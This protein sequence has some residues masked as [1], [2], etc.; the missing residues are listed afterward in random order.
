MKQ[1]PTPRRTAQKSQIQLAAEASAAQP[2]DPWIIWV[3]FRRCWAWA[4]P[5]GLVL[6]AIA[7]VVVLQMFVPTY[8]ATHII[9]ANEE[10]LLFKGVH[11]VNRNLA[12]TEK[13]L[14]LNPLVLDPVLANPDLRSAPSLSD[15]ETAESNLK[16]ALSFS[17][18]G[19]EA[20]LAVSYQDTTPEAAVEVCNA[21]VA[22]YMKFRAA[23][24]SKRVR[25]LETWLTPEIARWEQEVENDLKVVKDLRVQTNGYT[26]GNQA[27]QLENNSRYTRAAELRS[28]IGDL[29][30]AISIAEAGLAAQRQGG[31]SAFNEAPPVLVDPEIRVKRVEPTDFEITSQVKNDPAVAEVRHRIQ[32]YE[33]L[34]RAIEDQDRVGLKRKD[35]QRFKQLAA[36]AKLELEKVEAT[37]RVETKKKLI[38]L[39][40]DRYQKALAVAIAEDEA[41]RRGYEQRRIG[42]QAKEFAAEENKLKSLQGELE[43]LKPLYEEERARLEQYG[44]ATAELDFAEGELAVA[45]TILHKLRDRSAQIRTERRP[46]GA[47]RSLAEATLPRAAVEDLPYKQVFMVS[48]LAM[49]VPFLLGLLIE[50]RH[51][52]ITDSSMCDKSGLSVIGE[53]AQLPSGPRSTKGRRVF[54]ESIDTLRSSLFLSIDTKDTRSIAVVSSMSGEGKSSVSSQLAISIAKATG[55]TVL[56]VDADLRCPD[57][58]EIFGLDLGPGLSAVLSEAVELTDAIDKSLG[59]FVHVIPAGKL[60][61]SPHRL[62]TPQR[63]QAFIDLALKEYAYVVVDTAPVLSAG[64]SLAVASSV[65]ASLLCV[66]RDL[67]RVDSVTRTTR[68]LEA[69]GATIAGTVFSGVTAR[70]YAY[71]YGNYHYGVVPAGNLSGTSSSS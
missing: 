4:L 31:S 47:V 52:R 69:A 42:M 2:F 13:L 64:E 17:S 66:M 18:S 32:R 62:I 45:T 36:K 37:S 49:L 25:N 9:E 7:A 34:V 5:I 35:Y 11:P 22:S 23:H 28:K 58:H 41:A 57:Q 56:L 60:T 30:V 53:I 14:I 6:A 43:V 20:R 27:S 71:R 29:V 24:D 12:R 8:R 3:T 48:G 51:R 21:V 1:S 70:Q 46:E 40:E 61:S 67:S 44:G 68:R 65:D 38:E 15:P 55:E 19:S 10:Y 26:T 63:M 33:G 59:D 39:H 50:I 54:E 16:K